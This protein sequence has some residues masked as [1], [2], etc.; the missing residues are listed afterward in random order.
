MRMR[1]RIDFNQE[2][3]AV[4]WTQ[5]PESAGQQVSRSAGQQVSRSAG[6]QVSK[7]KKQQIRRAGLTV[8]LGND[9]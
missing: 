8:I 2:Q 6:Q 3:K 4:L 1:V 7:V 5:N 9:A